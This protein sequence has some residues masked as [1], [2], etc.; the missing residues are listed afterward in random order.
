MPVPAEEPPCP[1]CGAD[2]RCVLYRARDEWLDRPEVYGVVQCADCGHVYLSPRPTAAVQGDLYPPDFYAARRPDEEVR[3]AWDTETNRRKAAYL[4]LRPPGTCFEIGA[5]WGD[6]L[7]YMQAR[8]WTVHGCE[9]SPH[10]RNV[11]GLPI[12]RGPIEDAGLA[13]GSLDVVA[14]WAVLEH[15][16]DPVSVCSQVARALRPG[17]EFVFTVPNFD[18]LAARWMRLDDVPRHVQFFTPRSVR[19]LADAA[20]LSV[21]RFWF[22]DRLFAMSTRGLVEYTLR[23]MLGWNLTAYRREKRS[24]EELERRARLSAW[25]RLAEAGSGWAPVRLL[26]HALAPLLDRIAM[27]RGTYGTM[28]VRLRKPAD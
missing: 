28:T 25:R 7:Y 26:D 27:W 5:Y 10:P 15:L 13:P 14:A 2:E 21:E 11:F 18:S 4:A 8:G 16:A 19:R 20:G 17:G 6:W 3:A 12:V 1:L 22:D 23:R 24:R 9:P